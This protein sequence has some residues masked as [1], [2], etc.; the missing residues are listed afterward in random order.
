[1]AQRYKI[2]FLGSSAGAR[3]AEAQLFREKDKTGD[4]P[5][6]ITLRD[7]GAFRIIRKGATK[8][9]DTWVSTT[10]VEKDVMLEG[11][12]K[13]LTVSVKNTESAVSEPTEI[14]LYDAS[15]GGAAISLRTGLTSEYQ[16]LHWSGEKLLKGK[17]V[18]RARIYCSTENDGGI[19]Y[20]DV[21]AEK[22]DAGA[23][24]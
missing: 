23:G 16:K 7:I 5:T 22:I 19:F 15:L 14:Y 11:T 18:P 6:P 12:W 24:N 8:V 3:E 1:L 10:V 4:S 9:A 17:W 20:I 13:L 21:V 2:P